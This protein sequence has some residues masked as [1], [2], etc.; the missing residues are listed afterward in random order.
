[1]SINNTYTIVLTAR[2]VNGSA[3]LPSRIF[4]DDTKI[5][6]NVVDYK[7][8]AGPDSFFPI[9]QIIDFGDSSP[10][11]FK[12]ISIIK[13]FDASGQTLNTA[14]FNNISDALFNSTHTYKPTSTSQY[15]ALTAQIKITYNNFTNYVYYMPIVVAHNTYLNQ[16]NTLSIKSTQLI[17]LS[18][19]N[20]FMVL[21]TNRNDLYNIVLQD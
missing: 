12:N 16:F 18:A 7:N 15:T 21:T 10:Q 8:I 6:F 17:D 9:K 4:Q 2:G 20:I 13:K 14:I 11:Q 3:K 1:M 5:I 19:N